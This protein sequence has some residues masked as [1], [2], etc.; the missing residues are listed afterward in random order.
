[1]RWT[2]EAEAAVKRAPFFVRPLV[3]RR[4]EAEARK[5]GMEEV[6]AELL[7]ELKSKQHG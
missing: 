1:M 7:A 2:R 5:R 3:R 6:T 4:A